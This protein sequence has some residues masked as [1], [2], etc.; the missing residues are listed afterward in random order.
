MN[1][2][3]TPPRRIGC[4]M[5]PPTFTSR[6]S[7]HEEAS[8]ERID[9]YRLVRLRAMAARSNGGSRRG[10]VARG[11]YL[12]RI[13]GCNDCH[14]KGFAPSGGEVPESQWLAGDSLGYRG[15]W[16]TTYPSNLRLTF[17]KL[18]EDQWVEKG[19]S[20]Y[21]RPPMPWFSVRALTDSDLRALY[22]YV[23]T[24]QPLGTPAPAFLP[25]G[26]E[27]S[28]PSVLFPAPPGK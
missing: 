28:G 18:T 22:R 15:P 11:R 4:V 26:E 12:I 1:V 16:G 19:R 2:T 17:A 3:R 9:P 24:L 5:H 6:R 20:L 10:T 25:P 27:P 7:L 8:D 13:M 23:R 14:T 21:T